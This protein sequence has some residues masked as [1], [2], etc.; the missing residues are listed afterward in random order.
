[1]RDI[2]ASSITDAVT[3]LC[4]EANCSL[5]PDMFRA[6]DPGTERSPAGQHVLQI[7]KDNAH[8]ART[9]KLPY[10]QDTGTVGRHWRS[11]GGALG[12]RDEA[13][14]TRTA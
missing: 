6:L 14:S 12:L 1:M 5:E 2:H 8:L 13:I 10:C 9:R 4:M 11:E 7:L 3:K